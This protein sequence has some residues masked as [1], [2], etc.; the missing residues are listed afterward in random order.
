MYRVSTNISKEKFE[1]ML[2]GNK[3]YLSSKVKRALRDSKSHKILDKKYKNHK[4]YGDY[5]GCCECHIRPDV[6]L[7]YEIDDVNNIVLIDR[8]GSHS[9]LFG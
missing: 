9:E 6:L 5:V 3:G 4:L 1:R 2:S 8:I 7:V